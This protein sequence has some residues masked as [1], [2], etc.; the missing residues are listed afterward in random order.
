M[1]IYCT[2]C[3]NNKDKDPKPIEAIKRYKSER[4]TSIYNKS[5]DE[6]VDFRILSGK[7]G[8]IKPNDKISYYDK[9]LTKDKIFQ[10][11]DLINKQL[12]SQKIKEISF[13]TNDS[14][15][16]KPYEGLIKIVCS[17]LGIKLEIIEIK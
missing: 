17:E 7:Y 8:L 15:E 2:I 12:I 11:K 10:I 16:Y 13:F 4:I 9:L 6:G 3:S 1:K 5:K 14:K